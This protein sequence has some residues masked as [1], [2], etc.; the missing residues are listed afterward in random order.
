MVRQESRPLSEDEIDGARLDSLIDDMLETMRDENG[1]GL[2]APQVQ[3]GLR[4]IVYEIEPNERYPEL[5]DAVGPRVMINPEI[6]SRSREQTTN[7]EGCLSLPDLRAPVPRHESIVVE[8][9]DPDGDQRR[10]EADGFEARVIQ[11][12]LDHLDGTLFIDRVRDTESISFLREY[13][14]YHAEAPADDDG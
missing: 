4:V 6:E 14:R 5:E 7:W 12:E 13:R 2:A 9:T 11:H 10:I 8:Y 3:A 1:V